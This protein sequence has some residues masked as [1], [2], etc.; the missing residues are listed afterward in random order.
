MNQAAFAA[1]LCLLA[2]NLLAQD[3]A[4]PAA[5]A[6]NAVVPPRPSATPLTNSLIPNRTDFFKEHFFPYEPFY[7][8][9]GP[10]AP[11]AKFQISFKYRI[12]NNR[13]ALAQR[14]PWLT[15]LH[16]AY[17]QT[18]LWDLSQPSSPFLDTSYKPELLYLW[19]RVD[20]G[21]WADW[22]QLDLQG[23]LQ[24][25]SNG[26]EGLESRSLNIAYLR[27]TVRLGRADGFRFTLSPRVWAY[28]GGLEDN[29]DLAD[30]RGYADL[31]ATLGW[32]Q[33]LQ[34]A[35]TFRLGDDANHGSVQ[36]DLTYPM[37]RL[38][39]GSFSLYLHVQYFNGYGESLLRYNRR[40][41]TIRFGF[42]L[43][44]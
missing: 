21:R 25:E 37:Y 42:S 3:V 20:R 43:Y 18:S 26:R 1:A 19:E 4:P 41:D 16:A 28:V 12:L 39:S 17:T 29:P 40:S 24:H 23:G 2:A 44:R 27:P 8:I 33:G 5:A 6:T 7:F 10:D 36:L 9:A 32:A 22:F 38:L 30:Y 15:G 31:R 11:N 35:S 34:L 14:V 13:G